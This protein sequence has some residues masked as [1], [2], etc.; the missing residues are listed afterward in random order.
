MTKPLLGPGLRRAA[1]IIGAR[2]ECVGTI[3]DALAFQRDLIAEANEESSASPPIVPTALG[4]IDRAALLRAMWAELEAQTERLGPHW[5]SLYLHAA[6]KEKNTVGVDDWLDVGA[7]ADA[8]IAHIEIPEPNVLPPIKPVA[9]AMAAATPAD[10]IGMAAGMACETGD[11]RPEATIR[12]LRLLGF[13]V[14]RF[15]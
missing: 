3:G 7:L 12:H 6:D 8:V 10:A 2:L 5:E 4:S 1:E 14:V 13:D 15:R 11:F 9:D